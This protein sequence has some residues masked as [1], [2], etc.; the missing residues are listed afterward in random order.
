MLWYKKKSNIIFYYNVTLKT[1]VNNMLHQ[2]H[3]IE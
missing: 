3:R 2:N 1:M